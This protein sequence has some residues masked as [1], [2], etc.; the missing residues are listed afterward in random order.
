MPCGYR[1]ASWLLRAVLSLAAVWLVLEIWSPWVTV[2][3]AFVNDAMPAGAARRPHQRRPCLGPPSRGTLVV[4]RAESHDGGALEAVQRW[5]NETVEFWDALELWNA[6]PLKNDTHPD[7][8]ALQTQINSINKTLEEIQDARKIGLRGTGASDRL[9]RLLEPLLGLT[10]AYYQMR[11]A[12]TFSKRVVKKG[13]SSSVFYLSVGIAIFFFR[14]VLPR[15]L[16]AENLDDVFAAAELVGIPD[17]ATLATGLEAIQ[18]YDGLTKIA[19]YVLAFLVEKLILLSDILPIQIALKTVSP[20][21]FGGLLEG[22]LASAFCET[23]AAFCNFLLGRAFL[24]QRLQDLSFFGSP[25]LK[26]A[27]WYGA[28]S[29]SAA[30]DGFRLVLLLRLA[31]ILPLPF[32]SYWYML[33]ALPTP[34]V[35]FL[36][37]HFLGCLKTAFLDASFGVLLLTSIDPGNM[38]LKSQ[39]QQLVLVE[40]AAFAII[41][42]LVGTVATRLINDMLELD[43]DE[44]LEDNQNQVADGNHQETSSQSEPL[45]AEMEVA[46]GSTPRSPG[47]AAARKVD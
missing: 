23:L 35:E 30:Q 39:T 36:F 46:T 21:I 41:A 6:V 2:L 20:V 38:S 47:A 4:C 8:V 29:R 24:T 37:A 17:R 27:T 26:E 9:G 3:D 40:T 18:A 43:E 32:D 28:L 11:I 33:G 22:A 5:W 25:P 19:C 12:R 7:A 1:R 14:V 45:I 15:L 34:P 44:E 31:P 13:L 16:V 42:V 10:V